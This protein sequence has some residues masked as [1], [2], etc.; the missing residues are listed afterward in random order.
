MLVILDT[1]TFSRVCSL[2]PKPSLEIRVKRERAWYFSH[3]SDIQGR[4]DL[5]V[6]RQ[7]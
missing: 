7:A 6:H 3:V 5:I 2:V 1:S 4:K